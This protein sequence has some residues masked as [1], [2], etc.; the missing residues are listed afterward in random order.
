MFRVSPMRTL[1]AMA[2][3]AHLMAPPIP[4]PRRPHVE[5]PQPAKVRGSAPSIRQR[6]PVAIDPFQQKVNKLTA[7]QRHQWAR[8][9]Y[10]KD[11]ERFARMMKHPKSAGHAVGLVIAHAIRAAS[12][13]AIEAAE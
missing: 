2:S 3:L 1:L 5:E 10:P 12:D 9:G 7:W 11:I 13:A 6:R 4:Q 8:A